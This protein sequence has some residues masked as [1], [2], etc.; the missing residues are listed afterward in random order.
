MSVINANGMSVVLLARSVSVSREYLD[1]MEVRTNPL[2]FLLYN[3]T[4][5]GKIIAEISEAEAMAQLA[6]WPVR[7]PRPDEA[8]LPTSFLTEAGA[9]WIGEWTA[10]P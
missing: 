5:E 8:R 9:A 1:L 3:P 7:I 10:V 4:G 2:Q 6:A